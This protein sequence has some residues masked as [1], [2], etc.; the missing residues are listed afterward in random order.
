MHY[1]NLGLLAREVSLALAKLADAIDAGRLPAPSP[2][3]PAASTN[4]PHPPVAARPGERHDL[5]VAPFGKSKGIPLAEIDDAQL[6]WLAG[7][8][9][10]SVDDPSKATYR[11]KNS[12]DLES[13]RAE[14]ATR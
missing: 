10:T 9:Q 11:A 12:R 14:L 1:E 6:R 7:A 4:Q 2:A 5:P 13:V 3:P 8:L